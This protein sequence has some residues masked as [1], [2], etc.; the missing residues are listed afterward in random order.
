MKNKKDVICRNLNVAI[1]V[2]L[3]ALALALV[4]SA[5]ETKPAGPPTEQR[6]SRP[7]MPRMMQQFQTQCTSSMKQFQT[8]MS[9]LREAR[10]SNDAA[11][12]RAAIDD[13]LAIGASMN[14]NM[15]KMTNSC[16]SMT[17]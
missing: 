8:M 15:E 7:S 17:R 4:V 12:M 16:M 13:A 1:S 6:D 5:Q 2:I 10:A 11:R 3:T 9:K 14:K